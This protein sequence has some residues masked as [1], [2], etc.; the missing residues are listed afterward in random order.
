MSKS[1]SLASIPDVSLEPIDIRLRAFLA[2]KLASAPRLSEPL[3]SKRV[4]TFDCETRIDM[5]QRLRFGAFR[6]DDEIGGEMQLIEEGLFYDEAVLKPD[7]LDLLKAYARAN[8]M[9]LFPFEDF[10]E[11][12]LF[13][14]CYDLSGTIVGFNLPFDLSRLALNAKQARAV[15]HGDKT[16][17]NR[18]VDRRFKGGF[19]VELSSNPPRP[20]LRI[21]HVDR[22]RAFIQFHK[23]NWS[24]YSGYFVDVKTLAAAL[25]TG[26]TTLGSVARLLRTQTQKSTAEAHGAPLSQDYID[27]AINDVRCTWECYTALVERLAQHDLPDVRPMD[28][29]SEASIGKGYLRAMGIKPWRQSEKIFAPELIGIIMSSYF[30]GR[31]EVRVR[32]DVREVIYADFLSMYPTVNTLQGLWRFLIAEKTIVDDSDAATHWARDFLDSVTPETMLDQA[33]WPKLTAL[34][35]VEPEDDLLPIRAAF[36][37]SKSTNIG[38]N[39]LT[40]KKPLWFTLADCVAAKLLTGKAPHIVKAIRFSPGAPQKGLKSKTILGRE[41]GTIHPLEDDFFKRLIELRQDVKDERDL[42]R[43]DQQEY[44]RLN[45]DQDTIK[46]IAN[47]TSYGHLIE[48]N[49]DRGEEKKSQKVFGFVGEAQEINSDIVEKPGEFFH[50]LLATL[51]TGAARLMLALAER[52]AADERLIWSFCDTDG[53]ALAKPGDMTRE[54]FYTRTDRVLDWFKPLNPYAGQAG[55]SILRKERENFRRRDPKQ[56]EPLYCYAVS[57]KR[58][59]LFNI[60]DGKVLIRKASAH[61]LGFWRAPFLAEGETPDTGAPFWQSELWRL[62]C[63][64]ALDGK[65][66]D[67]FSLFDDERFGSTAA[68]QTTVSK[69]EFYKWFDRFNKGRDYRDRVQ[70]F[71]FLLRFPTKRRSEI[72]EQN[73]DFAEWCDNNPG[74]P[75]LIAPFDVDTDQV[76][77]DAFHREAAPGSKEADMDYG[78]WLTTFAAV[79]SEYD[80]HAEAKFHCGSGVQAGELQRRRV[81]VQYIWNVGKESHEWEENEALGLKAEPEIQFGQA[82]PPSEYMQSVI[83]T[84]LEE[85]RIGSNKLAERANVSKSSVAQVRNSAALVNA[86]S[87]TKMFRIVSQIA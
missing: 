76:A 15:S 66:S 84:A 44:D 55:K 67:G 42:A 12:I 26:A 65:D 50:P 17:K 46:I 56:P 52:K 14:Q 47:S 49:P 28:V 77:E 63:Q 29:F 27:Y 51:I 57:A 35:Q 43:D 71:N 16:S 78:H 81:C 73:P 33:T 30:G 5:S 45:T 11:Q 21:R 48:M 2:A 18:Y 9:R 60:C 54:E 62:I 23:E 10:T 87:L 4:L 7:E 58:Y 8:N 1:D 34:V 31:T 61:G 37:T 38:L 39:Y 83:R 19:K 13:Q 80:V 75:V 41:D 22:R 6:L 20:D 82:L 53:L 3:P 64:A 70:P 32:R 72:D 24:G 79:L 68:G 85:K 36:G 69:W 59:A 40:S 74:E 25:L 86:K